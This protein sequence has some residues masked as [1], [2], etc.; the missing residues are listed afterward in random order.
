[1]GVRTWGTSEQGQEEGGERQAVTGRE[2]GQR[3]VRKHTSLGTETASGDG[4]G[5]NKAKFTRGRVL[6]EILGHKFSVGDLKKSR[7]GGVQRQNAKDEW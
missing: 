2:G 6:R 3:L 1:M 5:N 7:L 4:D